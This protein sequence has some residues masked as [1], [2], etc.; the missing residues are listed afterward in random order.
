[1]ENSFVLKW[2]IKTATTTKMIKSLIL[3]YSIINKLTDDHHNDDD[4]DDDEF[5]YDAETHIEIRWKHTI[6][7]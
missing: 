4:Y 7:I 3:K 6:R 5:F 1:M 2:E